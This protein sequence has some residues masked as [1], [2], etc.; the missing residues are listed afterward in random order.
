MPVVFD[1]V[2]RP[3]DNGYSDSVI[4]RAMVVN[5]NSTPPPGR[6]SIADKGHVDEVQSHESPSSPNCS[7]DRKEDNLYDVPTSSHPMGAKHSSSV[8]LESKGTQKV[9]K[10]GAPI[11]PGE[12]AVEQKKVR[13][14]GSIYSNIPDHAS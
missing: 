9:S 5:D 12:Q 3:L 6:D 4:K 8:I 7:F 2:F 10:S 1:Y 11:P 14:K 13:K